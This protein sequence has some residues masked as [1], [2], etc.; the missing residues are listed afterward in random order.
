M[1]IPRI[2][3]LVSLP[4]AIIEPE[5]N[6][7]SI[8]WTAVLSVSLSSSTL[9]IGVTSLF[10][11]DEVFLEDLAAVFVFAMALSSFLLEVEVGLTFP[12]TA[13][14]FVW[15]AGGWV[16]VLA[17]EAFAASSLTDEDFEVVLVST[18]FSEAAT[19]FVDPFFEGA[20]VVIIFSCS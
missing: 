15:L 16:A 4:K 10:F 17:P 19:D 5:P 8:C 20:F 11:L 18:G 9:S 7:A 14:C 1:E 6:W 12:E 13:A 3:C 2:F